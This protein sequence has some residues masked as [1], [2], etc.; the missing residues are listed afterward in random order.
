VGFL[1][2]P[3]AS[4]A[5]GK[6]LKLSDETSGHAHLVLPG[7]TSMESGVDYEPGADIKGVMQP[8]MGP[9]STPGTWATFLLSLGRILKGDGAFSGKDSMKCCDDAGNLG[10]GAIVQRVNLYGRRR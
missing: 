7:H 10:A 3:P 2:C 4:A 6:P 9:C 5:R 8:V 1:G